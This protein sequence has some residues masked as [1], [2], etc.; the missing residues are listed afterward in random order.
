MR[1]NLNIDSQLLEEAKRV[2]GHRTK[3]D[4]VNEALREYI[5]RRQRLG[6]LEAF[7]TIDF[8][9]EFDYKEARKRR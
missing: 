8:D 2:G 6:A 5:A 1:R 3:R 7:G 4:A 9:P